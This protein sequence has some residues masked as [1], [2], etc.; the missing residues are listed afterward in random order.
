MKYALLLFVAALGI[1]SAAVYQTVLHRKPSKRTTM[2]QDGTWPNHVAKLRTSGKINKRS[3]SLSQPVN[4]YLDLEYFGN[5]TVGT[6][7]QQFMVVLDTG[8]SNFWVADTNVWHDMWHDTTVQQC[9]IIQLC[10]VW[11][12]IFH[13]LRYWICVHW[14]SRAGHFLR[15]FYEFLQKIM[16]SCPF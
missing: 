10:C 14:I 11:R 9:R 3:T 16:Q 6:P 7:P 13:Q 1:A 8:S 15:A 4:D 5:I 12:V 2:I